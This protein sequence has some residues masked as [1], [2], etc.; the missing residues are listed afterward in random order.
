M[1]NYE[2][3]AFENFWPLVENRDFYR[4]SDSVRFSDVVGFHVYADLRLNLD[5]AAAEDPRQAMKCVDLLEDFTAISERCA[6]LV[7][8]RVL[9][10]QGERIH[11][12]LP[13]L[14]AVSDLGKLLLFSSALTRTAYQEL[15]PAAGDDWQGFSMAAD[16]GSAVLIPSSFGGGSLV[17]LGIAANQPAKKLG[18]GVDSG[19][20][21]LPNRIGKSLPEAKQSGDWV[22]LNVNIPAAATQSFFDDNLTAGMRQAAKTILQERARR[23]QRNF[24]STMTAGIS[25]SSSPLKT[26]GM[27]LRADLDGFSKAVEEAFKNHKVLELVQ[28]FT[29]IM[30]YPEE[31]AEKLGRNRIEAPWAGDCCTILIQPRF[32]ETVEEM[33]AV[34]PVEAGR[35]WHGIAYENGGNKKWGATLGTAKWAV[36]LACGDSAEGGDGN[37]IITEF[38]ANGRS[39]RVIVGWCARRAKDAQEADGIKGD[40]VVV[41]SAV[42]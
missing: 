12:V 36:G 9:E 23:I 14:D 33:R 4:P 7:G 40:D 32:G 5:L 15:K 39:F 42:S 19:H 31:F 26:R 17:S 2:H 29:E 6:G 21:A 38:T 28:Q 18:Q 27:C 16:H 10:V 30:Q 13:A 20:L 34:L 1:K 37:A 25:F 11:F 22:Q 41:P 3:L 8:A 35:C 24:A